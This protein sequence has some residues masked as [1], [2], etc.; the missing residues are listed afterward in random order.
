M[1]ESKFKT[2]ME[3]ARSLGGDYSSGYQR[4]LRRHY[5][6]ED[7]GTEAEHQKWLTLDDYRQELG[8][9]YRDGF[10]GNPPRGMHGNTGNQHAVKSQ[11]LDSAINLR[12][13]ASDKAGWVKQA[14]A[15]G[16][17]LGPWVMK[18]L[19]AASAFNEG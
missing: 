18:T 7:F 5:H 13:S 11:T 6:G 2:Y 1:N 10:A 19:N 9:G 14:Q 15:E 8:D 16:M 12:C 4:G 3:A 17:K